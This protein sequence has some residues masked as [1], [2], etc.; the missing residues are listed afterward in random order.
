MGYRSEVVIKFSEEAV[1]VV[2]AARKICPHLDELLKIN[3]AH[4]RDVN[5]VS[6]L[7][8]ADI[9][10]YEGYPDIDSMTNLLSELDEEDY[11]FIRIGEE[12]TDTESMGVPW[13]YDMWVTRKISW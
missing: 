6:A 8:F 2:N 12:D 11:G 10:W 5:D 4:P 7:Y 9:K 13:E 1:E 3:D